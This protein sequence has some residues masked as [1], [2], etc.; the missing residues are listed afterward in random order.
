VSCVV[1]ALFLPLKPLPVPT[2][3]ALSF[4][5]VFKSLLLPFVVAIAAAA[6]AVAVA[7][8]V[9]VVVVV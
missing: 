7:V 2:L 3:P 4:T 8:L 6:A 5:L 9:V 1:W